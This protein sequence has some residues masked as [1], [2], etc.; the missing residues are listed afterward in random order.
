ML[1]DRSRP[2]ETGRAD[3][4]DK[5]STSVSLVARLLATQFPQWA[6]L[7]IKPVPSD[8]TQHALYRLGED[9]VVRLPQVEDAD[10]QARKEFQWLPLLAPCLPLAIPIPLVMGNPADGYP[11]HWSIYRWFEGDTAATDRIANPRQAATDLGKF[12]SALQR[13]DPADG[14]PS[15]R[16]RSLAERDPYTRAAIASLDGMIDADATTAAWEAS[17]MAP[18]RESAPVWVHGDLFPSNILVKD[19]RLSAIID[20]GDAGLSDPACDMLGAWSFLPVDVHDFFRTE[21]SVSD[22]TWVRGR[23]WALSIALL[24]LKYFR[25]ANVPIVHVATK[26]VRE[27]LADHKR[28][29]SG[30]R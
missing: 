5:V 11:W 10:G 21:L 7:P 9:M 15:A 6:D 13:V 30:L 23:G 2:W 16:G 17:L 20:F 19:G 12:I 24:A 28:S 27:V 14:P 1:G 18:A 25:G 3:L 26:V 29:S 8:G 4:P 22:A